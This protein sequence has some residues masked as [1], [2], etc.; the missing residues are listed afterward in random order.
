MGVFSDVFAI[1]YVCIILP[2]NLLFS[3]EVV[4]RLDD[5]SDE[6]RI[7]AAKTL[8][9]WFKF[10]DVRYERTTYR[11]HLE[12]LYRC[13]LVHLDDTDTTLQATV[14]SESIVYSPVI[15]SGAHNMEWT[16]E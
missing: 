10:I 5:A 4:K 3:T 16:L 14:L 2:I 15:S 12:F 13:L 1:F 9:L 6:V 11:G 7:T 8:S